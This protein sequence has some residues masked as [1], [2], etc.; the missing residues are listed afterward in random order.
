MAKFKFQLEPL[1][2]HRRREQ[3]QRQR[4]LADAMSQRV[5]LEDELRDMQTMI[6]SSKQNL[7]EHLV[8]RV[9]LN[10]VSDF[11][12][13]SGQVT[14]RAHGMIRRLAQAEQAV[15]QAR[16]VLLEASRAVKALELLRDKRYEAW[17]RALDRKETAEIDE[18]SSQAYIR[19]MGKKD[20][21]LRDE[22][23]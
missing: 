14:A 2:R 10:R 7:T 19:D 23:A 15:T 1:L 6:V 3:E 20:K 13:Y 9:D 16:E 5:A 21:R 11:A 18:I 4:D 8:G 17:K 22:A 12:R